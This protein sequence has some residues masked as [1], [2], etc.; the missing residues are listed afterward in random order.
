MRA[1]WI[2]L[3]AVVLLGAGVF[4]WMQFAPAEP[5]AEESPSPSVSPSLSP[6]VSADPTASWKTYTNIDYGFELTLPKTWPS[7]VVVKRVIQRS[8]FPG[9]TAYSAD[10]ELQKGTTYYSFNIKDGERDYSAFSFG[11]FP[12]AYWD[13]LQDEAPVIGRYITERDGRVFTWKGIQEPPQDVRLDAA[14]NQVLEIIASF[15]FIEKETAD[16]QNIRT[17]IENVLKQQSIQNIQLLSLDLQGGAVTM[18]FS[19]EISSQGQ[20]AFE[21]IFILVSNAIH[22]FLQ[23]VGS[24]TYEVYIDGVGVGEVFK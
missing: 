8:D 20:A 5:I 23:G 4:A 6:S 10:Y 1:V 18:N 3:G 19:K 7:Y 11:I 2:M 12:K 21:Q 9:G 24:I 16:E 22:P 17:A 15:K 13:T 14:M